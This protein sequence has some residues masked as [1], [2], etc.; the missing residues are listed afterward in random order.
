MAADWQR[1]HPALA[2]ALG[3]GGQGREFECLGIAL[4]QFGNWV[5]KIATK[6]RG[7]PYKNLGN[8]LEQTLKSASSLIQQHSDSMKDI[9]KDGWTHYQANLRQSKIFEEIGLASEILDSNEGTN[10]EKTD[11]GE[12][13]ID[14]IKELLKKP[15]V[16]WAPKWVQ[17]L[18]DSLFKV[19]DEILKLLK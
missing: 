8:L 2:E 7:E 19:I 3:S 16:W 13:V 5:G 4:E 17:D 18:I 1:R 14:T 12:A 6:D 11:K 10:G 9:A 15:F